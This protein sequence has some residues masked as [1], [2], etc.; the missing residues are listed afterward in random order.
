MGIIKRK[1]FKWL[2][3][4]LM[5]YMKSGVRNQTLCNLEL[6]N[7]DWDRKTIKYKSKLDKIGKIFIDDD[8]VKWLEKLI[9]N[10]KTNKVITD[11]KWIF[12]TKR[13][14]PHTNNVISTYFLKI[15]KELKEQYP[16]FNDKIT[17]H[18][19]RRYFINK[20]LRLGLGLSLVR[21]SVNHSNYDTLLK[22]ESDII[23]DEDL[24]KTTLPT[25]TL[26]DE[27]PTTEDNIRKLNQQMKDLKKELEHQLSKS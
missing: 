9:I 23:M 4:M 3:P 6:K 13:G 24:S 15:R 8:L 20:G 18:S 5:V 17:I 26:D 10:P 25:P 16:Q 19:F 12:E 11:R 1:E 7:V 27:K 14:I 21:K 22:Y 2:L